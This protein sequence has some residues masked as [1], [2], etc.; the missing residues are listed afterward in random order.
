[1]LYAPYTPS[2]SS[3]VF[4]IDFSRRGRGFEL[5][6]HP[7][8]PGDSNI[9]AGHRETIPCFAPSRYTSPTVN[10]PLPSTFN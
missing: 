3:E 4:D 9:T 6:E 1:M 2:A 5:S 7:L 8:L 10:T